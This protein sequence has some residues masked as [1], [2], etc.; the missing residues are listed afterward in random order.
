MRTKS[1]R[2]MPFMLAC[3]LSWVPP[4][5]GEEP[6]NAPTESGAAKPAGADGRVKQEVE[7]LVQQIKK[8]PLKPS[9]AKEGRVLYVMDIET[10]AATLFADEPAEGLVY[11]GSPEWS[12]DGSQVLY[13]AAPAPGNLFHLARIESV[14]AGDEEV[15]VTDV[16][17]GNCPCLTPDSDRIIFLLNPGAVPGA[18]AGTWIMQATGEHRRS[19]CEFG[20]PKLSPDGNHLLLVG[21]GDP[22]NLAII[23]IKTAK[24]NRLTLPNEHIYTNPSWVDNNT[25][26]AGIGDDVANAIA[27]LDVSKPE[28][29]SVKEVLWKKT[30]TLDLIPV[31]PIYSPQKR[32][33]LFI[34]RERKG[35]S[36]GALYSLEPGGKASPKKY[37][38]SGYGHALSDPIVSPDG[39][40]ILF[41]SERVVPQK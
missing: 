37:V 41:S 36:E 33:Y 38:R 17:P 9:K 25:L 39:R 21:F 40:Y 14:I 1:L 19:L 16:G 22:T 32:R 20:R 28:E 3:L 2:I 35:E 27:L 10:G 6:K 11:L 26:V 5:K 30:P 24:L 12:Q 29:F 13:D 15:E 7:R 23:D 4:M 34:G 31:Y 18:D 8:H